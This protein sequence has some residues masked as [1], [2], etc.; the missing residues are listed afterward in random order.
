MVASVCLFHWSRQGKSEWS[1]TKVKLCIKL[2]LTDFCIRTW[3]LVKIN[4]R[5]CFQLRCITQKWKEKTLLRFLKFTEE[6]P[7]INI[8]KMSHFLF[9]RFLK[10]RRS[11][12][13]DKP[14]FISAIQLFCNSIKLTSKSIETVHHS[15]KIGMQLGSL[16]NMYVPI[17][18]T[19]LPILWCEC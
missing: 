18:F 11:G 17:D 1:G 13:F 16:L 6:L 14:P 4:C 8:N 9:W 10:L 19:Q 15:I 7:N 3:T 2:W 12:C 5:F